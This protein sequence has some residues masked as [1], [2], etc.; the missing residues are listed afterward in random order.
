MTKLLSLTLF[1]LIGKVS[2][3]EILF[4]EYLTTGPAPT[5]IIAPGCGGVSPKAG[6]V[7]YQNWAKTFQ[8]WGYNAVILDPDTGRGFPNGVCQTWDVAPSVVSEDAETVAA[9]IKRQPWHKGSIALIGFSRGGSVALN[10]AA[11]P[12]VKNIKATIAFYPGCGN[13]YVGRFYVKPV[14]PIQVHFGDKD[15]WTPM[16]RCYFPLHQVFIYPNATHAFDFPFPYRVIYNKYHLEYN[17]S[18]HEESKIR[19]KEFLEKQLS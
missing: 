12:D 2:A 18:A 9:Y 15:D 10:I 13:E 5:V 17:R 3:G 6:G 1:C 8:D 14:K 7:S 11:N 4:T 16:S 19:V